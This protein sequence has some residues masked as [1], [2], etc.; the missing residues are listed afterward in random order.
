MAYVFKLNPHN[1]SL[2]KKRSQYHELHGGD[3]E[4]EFKV[5][6]ANGRVLGIVFDNK[7]NNHTAQ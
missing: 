4:R 5:R 3:K 1:R 2:R 7:L 6:K